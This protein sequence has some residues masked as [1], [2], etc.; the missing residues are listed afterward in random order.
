[1]P[2]VGIIVAVIGILVYPVENYLR[3]SKQPFVI[4]SIAALGFIN[5]AI[6]FAF[7]LS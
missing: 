7:Y 5:L 2:I 4:P 3:A 1:M 6:A